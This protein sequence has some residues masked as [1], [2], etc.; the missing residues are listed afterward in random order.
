MF[1]CLC[2]CAWLCVADQGED[3]VPLQSERGRGR[4]SLPPKRTVGTGVLFSGFGGKNDGP[5][6]PGGFFHLPGP[7]FC[8]KRTPM[9]AG[10]ALRASAMHIAASL[11][12]QFRSEARS[13][14][15]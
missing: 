4:L 9:I 15:S 3:R 1:V 2:V 5:G 8:P 6:L 14:E 7:S 10:S 13:R 12:K 11:I